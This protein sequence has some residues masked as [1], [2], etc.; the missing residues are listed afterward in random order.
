[1]TV[2][3]RNDNV[4][5]E[6]ESWQ[7]SCLIS[8]RP[9]FVL[10]FY[11]F[12]YFYYSWCSFSYC[13]KCAGLPL[14]FYTVCRVTSYILYS[15]QRYFLYCIQCTDLLLILYTVYTIQCAEWLPLLYTVCRVTSI[16]VSSSPSYCWHNSMGLLY[17]RTVHYDWSFSQQ[18]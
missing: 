8:V 10:N 16:T 6:P 13:L 5:P 3:P 15:V 2:P 1:M 14:I 9:F 4:G 17:T 11:L 18:F 12:I 7:L